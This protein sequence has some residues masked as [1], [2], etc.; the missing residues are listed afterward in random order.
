MP[1]TF[2]GATAEALGGAIVAG[3][4]G[5]GDS[6]P[7]ESELC[8]Q[9]GVS[10][11][12]VREAIKSLAAKGL[13]IAA[14]KVGTRVQPQDDWNWFD[15]QIIRW[16]AKA[17]LTP[18]FLRDLMDLRR[19]VEP[20][21]VRLA[22]ERATEADVARI[23]AA[24]QGMAKAIEE[25]GDYISSDLAFH[26]GIL[27][28][29]RNRLL[30]QMSNALAALLRT[31]FEVS[32]TRPEGPRQSLPDHRRVLEAIA[33]RDP[34]AGVAAIEKLISGAY[35]DIDAVLRS[36]RKLPDLSHPAQMLRASPAHTRRLRAASAK[37]KASSP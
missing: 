29:C 9:F 2:H 5:V 31:S 20:A 28:A 19:V 12:V 26:Q 36:R 23:R 7:V 3:R 22:C 27:R 32:T 34:A 37:L 8:T 10:R 35:D 1:H 25:G 6:L 33:A 11:T 13:V 4:Y 21:A 24:Y 18:E 16:Q 15:P 17:G 14:P 30:T